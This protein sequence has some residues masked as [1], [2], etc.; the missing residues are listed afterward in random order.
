MGPGFWDGPAI[1]RNGSLTTGDIV[2][3]LEDT[4]HLPAKNLSKLGLAISICHFKAADAGV[5]N[6]A[7]RRK[8]LWPPSGAFNEL[9]AGIPVLGGLHHDYRRAAKRKRAARTHCPT[10][11]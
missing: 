1:S 8:G 5:K 4:T 10:R 6:K 7:F 3:R 2:E 9:A 11:G